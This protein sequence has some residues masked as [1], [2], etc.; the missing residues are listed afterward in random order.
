MEAIAAVGVASAAIQ[1]FEF[2]AKTMTLCKEI[3]DSSTD[4]T[5]TNEQMSRSIKELTQL[6]KPLRQ[7]ANTS[8]S[9]YRHVVRANQDCLRVA[10]ELLDLLE[11]IRSVAQ[12]SQLRSALRA[13]KE[14]KT[15]DKLQIRLAAC[16]AKLQLAHT[17]DVHKTVNKVLDI[18]GIS[19]ATI[20]KIQPQLQQLQVESSARQS[21]TTSRLDAFEQTFATFA[22]TVNAQLVAVTEN[23]SNRTLISDDGLGRRGDESMHANKRL[24]ETARLSHLMDV[25][26]KDFLNTIFFNEMFARQKDIRSPGKDDFPWIFSNTS[27]CGSQLE[28]KNT[29]QLGGIRRDILTWLRS[30]RTLF[31]IAG[32]PGS[33]KSYLMSFI[34]SDERTRLALKV[35]ARTRRLYIF[36]FFFWSAGSP[37]QKSIDGLLRCILFQAL[38]AKP[39]A[40]KHIGSDLDSV[41]FG[42]WTTKQLLVAVMKA[43]DGY[44]ND[45]IFLLVDGLDELKGQPD[46]LIKTLIDMQRGSNIKMLLSCRPWQ[47]LNKELDRFPS[48]KLDDLNSED[49]AKFARKQLRSHGIDSTQLVQGITQR[50][51]GVFLWTVLVC[52]ILL[53]RFREGCNLA[54]L[55]S[56]L[57]AIP[58][59]LTDLFAFFL[60]D[61]DSMW[62]QAVAGNTLGVQSAAGKECAAPKRRL[63]LRWTESR[64]RLMELILRSTADSYQEARLLSR[65]HEEVKADVII[66]QDG[67][68]FIYDHRL[69]PAEPWRRESSHLVLLHSW[70]DNRTALEDDTNLEVVDE[71][72][73]D[74]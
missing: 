2:S 50:A 21:A 61:I 66:S 71:L 59:N 18:Q 57:D 32:E 36:K 6:L 7:S 51:G 35:W 13:V 3:R 65:S 46:L 23:I 19:N 53:R 68:L 45:C 1:F 4:S 52:R 9:T 58:T 74:V 29:A 39:T 73:E 44:K 55:R 17:M 70:S 43:L 8:S 34:V 12:K 60:R 37:L 47:V 41:Q 63:E 25:V 69:A 31:R 56:D 22:D 27:P 28:T 42:G 48:V 16:Q 64:S 38:K 67:K 62:L 10:D 15:I 11:Y 20:Q 33:G 26:L 49:I 40:I 54:G 14:R 24:I 30:D 5:K 72:E